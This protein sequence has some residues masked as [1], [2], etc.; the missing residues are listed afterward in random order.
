MFRHYIPGGR[1][2]GRDAFSDIDKEIATDTPRLAAYCFGTAPQD[3]A[4]P[5]EETAEKI[6]TRVL[7]EGRAGRSKRD[8]SP[9]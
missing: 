3:W 9:E 8:R 5:M 1:R 4:D 6:P 2:A 7:A